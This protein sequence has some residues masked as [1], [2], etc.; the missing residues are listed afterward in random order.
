MKKRRFLL[1][2]CTFVLVL[3]S[4]IQAQTP[5]AY[6]VKNVTIHNS[7]GSTIESGTI[8]W[9]NGIIQHI[10]NNV[11]IPFDAFTVDGG[12]SMH[13]YPGFV[14]GLATWGSPA[15]PNVQAPRDPGNPGYARAGIEPNREPSK[16]ID[17]NHKDFKAAMQAGFTTAALGLLG[18]MLP[19]QVDIVQ[20]SESNVNDN[21]YKNRVAHLSKLTRARRGAYPGTIMGV[22]ARFRQLMYDAKALQDHMAYHAA[23]P[24]MQAPQRDEVLESLFPI[25]NKEV[26]L[27]YVLDTKEDIEKMMILKQEFGFD[28]V[29]VSGKEAYKKADVLKANNIPVLVS[30]DLPDAPKW[31]N[32]KEDEDAKPVNFEE[33]SYRDRQ[34][35]EYKN[36]VSN[37]KT[38]IDAGVKVGFASNGTSLKDLKKSV[39]AMMKESGIS[40]TELI[41][42]MT[43][44]TAEILGVGSAM[45]SLEQGKAANFALYT[46]PILDKKTKVTH[47]VA[48][49]I[50]YDF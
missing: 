40:E 44:N 1:C 16:V 35:E 5:P 30:F 41:Y 42:I 50:I 7:D 8:V 33:K 29:I 28:V 49:G 31:Y 21:L 3:Y 48:N 27:Y 37:A 11:S 32:K 17:G 38:L 2:V 15:R 10:G 39:E 22:M 19:G 12:D 26:P 18:E 23:N 14:D 43:Q 45:G 6:A 47:S 9:R 25:L 24:N 4:S 13:V 46:K 20:L 36:R 34:L